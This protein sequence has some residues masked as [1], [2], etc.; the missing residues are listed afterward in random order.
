MGLTSMVP[1][2]C[3]S[4]LRTLLR[5]LLRTFEKSTLSDPAGVSTDIW[6]S[7]MSS[8]ELTDSGLSLPVVSLLLIMT[9][10]IRVLNG[11]SLTLWLALE[12]LPTRLQILARLP[13]TV[14]P[15]QRWT[16]MSP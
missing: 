5:C 14:T 9:S 12:R 6:H 11:L 15:L 7:L 10:D 16:P 4:R 1:R 8:G 3:I 13:V 2:R